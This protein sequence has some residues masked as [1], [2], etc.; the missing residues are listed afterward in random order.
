M[1][2]G[3]RVSGWVR[4]SVRVFDEFFVHLVKSQD[5]DLLGQQYVK[6]P[7]EWYGVM[8]QAARQSL[9]DVAP[10]AASAQPMASRQL[11]QELEEVLEDA[12]PLPQGL[13]KAG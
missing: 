10:G 8:S 13:E 3:K 9:V 6:R 4:R 7:A 12:G 1:F 2:W 5:L 11:E